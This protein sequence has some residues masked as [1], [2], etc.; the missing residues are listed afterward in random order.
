MIS[1]IIPVFNSSSQICGLVDSLLDQTFSDI[2]VIFVD[3]GSTDNCYSILKQYALEHCSIKVIRKPN[4]GVSSARNAGLK[5][6]TGDYIGFVD[7][8][9][10]IEPDMYE[11]MVRAMEDNNAQLVSCDLYQD[12]ADVQ[13]YITYDEGESYDVEILEV[14]NPY[15]DILLI[16]Q[17]AGYLWNKLF[18]KD[19]I[20]Q[21]L[22]EELSQ[23]EDL[24][25]VAQYLK[26]V[27]KMVH[28]NKKL[29][30]YRMGDP[31][32]RI[33]LTNRSL[34]L[35]QAYEKI[36]DC[37]ISDVPALAWLPRKN[38]LKVYLNFNA[39]YKLS[40]MVD[41]AVYDRIQQGINRYLSSVIKDHNVSLGEKLNILLTWMFPKLLL[42][43]KNK[44][45]SERHKN[46][47]WS[48]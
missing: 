29:Y 15:R 24:L 30:H 13:P 8:D 9:D 12:E 38:L 48:K 3:D 47:D 16:P 42:T 18:K 20:T 4:G 45:L 39:R 28:I 41:R 27:T 44:Q 23:N 14:K 10:W 35:M 1:V 26:S 21:M 6:A 43:I 2:E 40:K 25:F 36:L 37:Y 33:D 19:L 7:A 5:I 17:I 31:T 32:P 46:G 34:S 11:S 22:D